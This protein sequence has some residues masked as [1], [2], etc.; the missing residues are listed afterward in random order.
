M[1]GLVVTGYASLD[2]VIGLAGQAQGDA[3]TLIAHRDPAA[4]PRA[5]GCP[6]YIA[7]AA[8]RAGQQAFP[9]SW[10]GQGPEAALYCAALVRLGLPLDGIA[11]VDAERSPTALMIYQADGSCICLYDPALGRQERLTPAQAALIAAA[12]HVCIAVGPPQ[13]QAAILAACPR[14]ARVYW[15]V[16]NDPDSFG[17]AIRNDLSARADVILCSAAERGLIG[18]TGALIVETRGKEGVVLHTPGKPAR[19][20]SIAAIAARDTTGAGDS[21]AG[22]FIAA[23]MAGEPPERAVLAGIRAAAALLRDRQGGGAR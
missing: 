7:A 12:S 2:Y 8:R 14:A 23:E 18:P 10:I 4:W 17:P 11:A 5:G 13:L 22:G 15:A 21:L 6:A 20:H 3:T 16:K 9:L 1:T 19:H